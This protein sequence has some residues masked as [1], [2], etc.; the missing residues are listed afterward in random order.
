MAV[1]ASM[2]RFARFHVTGGLLHVISRFHDRRYYLDI[3]GARERYL[4]LL[5][6]AA[7]THDSR[8][9]AYCLMS[10]HVHLVL[11]LGNDPLGRL[12]KQVHAPFGNWVNFQRKGMG[13]ILSDRPKSVLV[14]SETHGME[15]V[16]YVHNNPVR[17]GVVARASESAWSSHRAYL[18]LAPSPS[19][20]ATEAVLGA[21]EAEHESARRDLAHFV[22]EGRNEERRPEFSG[23]VSKKLM[24]RMRKLMGGDL[25]LSYPVLGPDGF[26]VDAL[27]E[28]ERRHRRREAGFARDIAIDDVVR[29]VFEAMGLDPR[30][31]RMRVKPSNVARGRA[32]AAWL[33]VE[34][35]GRPQVMA[36]DGLGVRPNTISG[37]LTQRRRK[38]IDTEDQ[39]LLEMVLES[40]TEGDGERES[41]GETEPE[42]LKPRVLVL[43]RQR[44][45]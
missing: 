6:R 39:R 38:G 36:S 12:T 45:G 3:D 5:G 24:R 37:M 26:V 10:S 32:L 40:L 29:A 19:W 25:E 34:R 8:I 21:D 13:A 27:R 42:A 28:Q 31:A 16:R 11:Q 30:L 22:D 4:T 35:L 15:I 2:P 33:W 18:G 1:L 20:L 43:K 17:A 41:T 14:D 7:E 9:I 23:E 44:R